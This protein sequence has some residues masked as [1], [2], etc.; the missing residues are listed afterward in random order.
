MPDEFKTTVA[1]YVAML[2]EA[3]ARKPTKATFMAYEAGLQGLGVEQVRMACVSSLQQN[4]QYMP[5][6]GELR[7]L[8]L[9]SGRT[10]ESVVADAWECLGRG[11]LR[12]GSSGSPNFEDG[13]INAAV[14]HLGGWER[15]CGLSSDEFEK[16]FRKDFER[17]Y[18]QFLRTG[19]TGELRAPL[20]GS[21][22]R[23][24]AAYH[25][26]TNP[27]SGS[28]YELPAPIDIPAGYKPNVPSLPAPTR[29]P[30]DVPMIEFRKAEPDPVEGSE[31]K[32][33]RMERCREIP[34]HL[35]WHDKADLEFKLTPEQLATQERNR[36]M[37]EALPPHPQEPTDA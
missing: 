14:R 27:R 21:I 29:R 35:R 8:G 2:C 4:R 28:T 3:F 17:V 7:E 18:L 32:P 25:G 22:E 5:T 19:C 12:V 11:I 33:V 9:S 30:V 34:K 15:V 20:V 23:E 24:S 6:P 36:K 13:L 10:F 1:T 31:K 16:W 26:K 37:L